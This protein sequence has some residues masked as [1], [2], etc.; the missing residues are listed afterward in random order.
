MINLSNTLA[1]FGILLI[2]GGCQA[3]K[4]E[5]S[6]AIFNG[7]AL[8][9]H[10]L[11]LNKSSANFETGKLTISGSISPIEKRPDVPCGELSLQLFNSKG[12]L[13][14][15]ITTD[16]SPCHL[17]YGPHTTRPGNFIVIVNEIAVQPLMIKVNY[18]KK[19]HHDH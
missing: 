17:H 19:A 13:L 18:K 5:T 14:K 4:T 9:E 3:T 8:R 7:T 10:N 16:Y 11:E 1:L 12:L 15:E 6:D 2:L